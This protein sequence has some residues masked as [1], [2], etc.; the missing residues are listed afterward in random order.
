MGPPGN[1]GAT[2]AINGDSNSLII[3]QSAEIR[4]IQKNWIDDQ[5]FGWVVTYQRESNSRRTFER[6]AAT[7]RQLHIVERLVEHRTLDVKRTL[8]RL[9]HQV[10]GDVHADAVRA[11]HIEL[12]LLW[13]GSGSNFKVIFKL[14]RISV[15][16]KIDSGVHVFVV[17]LAI[18]S[19]V[20][21]PLRTVAPNEVIRL[22][23]QGAFADGQRVGIRTYQIQLNHG[24]T[25]RLIRLG[26]RLRCCV[27]N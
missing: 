22:S 4:G 9:Q 7:D 1:I 17:N 23:R 3:R 5:R 19:D 6:K 18:R 26:I 14:R 2:L 13:I 12:N 24:P 15:I 27:R 16:H 25:L 10:A 8:F 21:M 20:G 11:F